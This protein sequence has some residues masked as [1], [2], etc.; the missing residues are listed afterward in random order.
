[1]VIKADFFGNRFFLWENSGKTILE[2][3]YSF[4][5]RVYNTKYL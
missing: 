1:M 5:K 3:V 4:M 2:T